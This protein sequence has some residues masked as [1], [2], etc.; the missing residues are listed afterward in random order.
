MLTLKDNLFYIGVIIFSLSIFVEHL[1]SIETNLTCFLKG[2]ACGLELIGVVVLI[3]K[4]RKEM[5]AAPDFV[6]APPQLFFL[7]SYFEKRFDG[8]MFFR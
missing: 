6:N 8:L 5:I 4:K 7:V 1:F 3:M 2:F